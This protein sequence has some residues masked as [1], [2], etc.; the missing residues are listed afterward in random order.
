MAW[1][2]K[3]ITQFSCENKGKNNCSKAYTEPNKK[4]KNIVIPVCF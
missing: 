2:P 4:E 1:F 3:F